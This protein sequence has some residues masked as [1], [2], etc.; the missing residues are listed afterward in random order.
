M[1]LNSPRIIT[2]WITVALAAIGL[3]LQIIG[4]AAPL[5]ILA[6][7]S[8]WVVLVAFVVLALANVLEGL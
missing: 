3:L 5:P 7:I 6:T 1:R 2:F 8:F 4:L